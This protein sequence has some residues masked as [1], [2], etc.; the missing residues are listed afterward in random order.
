M[1]L[2]TVDEHLSKQQLKRLQ[3]L[4]PSFENLR[5]PENPSRLCMRWAMNL[6]IAIGEA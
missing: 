2:E 1:K 3:Q 6:L 5:R 4:E